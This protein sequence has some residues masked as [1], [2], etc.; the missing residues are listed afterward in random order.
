MKKKWK[1]ILVCLFPLVVIFLWVAVFHI[2]QLKY[3]SFAP[4]YVLWC[5]GLL[6]FPEKN[7]EGYLYFD[8]GRNGLVKDIDKEKLKLKFPNLHKKPVTNWQRQ[9]DERLTDTDYLW[10]GDTQ[11]IIVFKNNLGNEIVLRKE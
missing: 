5:N 8:S 1:I 4:E 2:P 6:P 9:I 10:I 3:E 11:W 7:I